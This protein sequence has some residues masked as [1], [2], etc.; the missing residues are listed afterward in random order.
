MKDLTE[1][2]NEGSQIKGLRPVFYFNNMD[3]FKTMTD[4]DEQKHI[5]ASYEKTNGNV[6]IYFFY[7]Q[8]QVGYLKMKPISLV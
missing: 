1:Y 7:K 6:L 8:Q 3:F 4:P 2:I 5:T